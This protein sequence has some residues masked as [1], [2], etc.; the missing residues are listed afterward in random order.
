MRLESG[1]GRPGT[2]RKAMT[3]AHWGNIEMPSWIVFGSL[4]LIE[5]HTTLSAHPF[6]VRLP[7]GRYVITAE[8]GKEY[9]LERRVVTVGTEPIRL[10]IRLRRWIDMAERGWYSGDTHTHRTIAELPNVML[11]EDLNVA[12]PLVDWVHEAFV[13][14][15]E[16]RAASF[17]D[18][19]AEPIK[20]DATHL[21]VPRNTEY[22]FA[23]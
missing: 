20:V 11:A 21:I 22:E 3:T 1:L 18:P 5:M 13:A 7:P 12:F 14:P 16:R 23:A 10:A 8:R 9:H 15:I 17:H 6:T 19:G 2:D 4:F